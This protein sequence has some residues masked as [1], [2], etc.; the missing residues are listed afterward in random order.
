MSIKTLKPSLRNSQETYQLEKLRADSLRDENAPVSGL[1]A[2][3]RPADWV[4][5]PAVTN[6][7]EKFV[8]IWAV[9]PNQSLCAVYCETDSGTYTVNWGDGTANT[10]SSSGVTSYHIF[11]Y[12]AAAL[13]AT[14]STRGYKQSIITVTPTTS[15]ITRID[16]SRRHN[17]SNAQRYSSMY[18]DISMSL[19]YCTYISLGQDESTWH[20]HLEQ[21][22]IYKYSDDWEDLGYLFRHCRVLASIP[23]FYTG[24]AAKYADY[25]FN[26]CHGLRSVP[27]IMQPFFN[28]VQSCV[29]LFQSCF[30]LVTVELSLPIVYA[31]QNIF[32]DCQALK[33]AVIL[34]IGSNNTTNT[35]DGSWPGTTDCSGWFGG[36]TVH[37]LTHVEIYKTSRV[38]NFNSTFSQCRSLETVY[39]DPNTTSLVSV[40]NMFSSC[41]HLKH[42]PF[43]NTKNVIYWNNFAAGCYQLEYVP[44]YDFSGPDTWPA[45]DGS[46]SQNFASAF[47]SCYVLKQL[48]VMNMGRP[49]DTSYMCSSSYGLE[50]V[51]E[52]TNLSNTVNAYWMFYGCQ[53]IKNT[54]SLVF[55]K[56]T[57]AS[58]MF[59]DCRKLINV[60]LTISNT[61]TSFSTTF[62][63]CHSLQNV[64]ISGNTAGIT[65]TDSMFSY[66]YAMQ[67]APFFDTSRVTNMD[68]M[69]YQCHSLVNI[70]VYNTGNNT[71]FNSMMR[72]CHALEYP[73]A[74]NTSKGTLFQYTFNDSETIKIIPNYNTSNGTNFD[75]FASGCVALKSAPTMNVYSGTYL[76]SMFGSCYSMQIANTIYGIRYTTDFDRNHLSNTALND[77]YTALPNVVSKTIYVTYNWG[78]VSDNTTIATSKG[79]TVSG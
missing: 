42:I 9:A 77:L 75:N 10:V 13:S 66:C 36:D 67:T 28:Q 60:D 21:I 69:F 39:I 45:G 20:Q 18:L 6:A 56:M 34:D 5:L 52:M 57:S 29:G 14:T 7:D 23:V 8:G 61:C 65:T 1:A 30:G 76:R 35:N 54:G 2:W 27:T 41:N 68:T 71:N 59:A 22:K 24:T 47:D 49:Y 72:S 58:Y 79:W 73:P 64:T 4:A 3:T 19:P 33:R 62:Q 32:Y 48:P 78:T 70:P 51:P 16:L 26:A 46:T 44:P 53:E 12:A 11:D 15:H 63:G 25:M 43:F 40:D 37:A 38:R 31:A 55:P 17:A 74:L 50:K